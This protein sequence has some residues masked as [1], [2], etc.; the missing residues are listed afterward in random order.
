MQIIFP[1]FFSLYAALAWLENR[2]IR[3]R[4]M[5]IGRDRARRFITEAP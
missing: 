4:V 1:R 2:N 3:L 5:R